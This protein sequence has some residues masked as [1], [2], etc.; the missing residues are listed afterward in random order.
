[1][2]NAANSYNNKRALNQLAI[3]A[4]INGI[5]SFETILIGL[6]PS[7]IVDTV[8]FD[9]STVIADRSA[10]SIEE[11]IIEY[12]KITESAIVID[13]EFLNSEK[14]AEDTLVESDLVN[15][16]KAYSFYFGRSIEE[17]IAEND[18][19]IENTVSNEI[20]PLNFKKI[21]R[22]SSLSKQLKRRTLIGMN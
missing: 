6:I 5:E 10:K 8:A 16:E 9:P 15:V 17:I 18:R 13:F 3:S 12:N 21:N 19:I 14:N 1:M 2:A 22:N 11:I 20:K 4:D 7:P